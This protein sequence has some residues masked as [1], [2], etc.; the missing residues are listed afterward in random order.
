MNSLKTA[1][2]IH[3]ET[4]L[5]VIGALAGFAAQNAALNIITSGKASTGK[6]RS[7]AIV[8][9]KT[10]E[11]FLFGDA[12]NAFLFPEL[13]SV[14]PLAA[15]IC[16]AAV[17]AGV[18]EADLPK[19]GEMAAHVARVVGGATEFCKLRERPGVEP[20][21]QPVAALIKFW[22]DTRDML[23][24][25]PVKPFFGR[26]ESSLEEIHW[27]IVLGLVA[28]R[29]IAMTKQTLNP[30]IGAAIVMESAIIT[31]KIDPQRIEPG[32]WRIDTGNSQQPVVRLRY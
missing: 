3:S 24:R 15:L 14:L 18:V 22:P 8:S 7:L 26:R 6:P 29:Y 31:S 19:V 13:G 10:G 2:G 32:K 27:S 23:A 9:A 25:P 16:G 30:S 28:S 4:L 5:V 11:I 21:L 17:K 12:I 1:R 20:H